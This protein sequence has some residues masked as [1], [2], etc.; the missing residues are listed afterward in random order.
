[1]ERIGYEVEALKSNRE[2]W[3]GDVLVSKGGGYI[4]GPLDLAAH[5]HIIADELLHLGFSEVQ[6]WKITRTETRVRV[7]FD[8][9]GPN[10]PAEER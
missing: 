2:Q 5:A 4:Y 9:A 6:V 7:D 8:E 3:L 10:F 1:M